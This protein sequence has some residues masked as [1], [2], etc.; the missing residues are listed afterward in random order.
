MEKILFYLKEMLEDT[1]LKIIFSNGSSEALYRK[2]VII[3]KNGYY[4]A[5][6]FT[7][8]QV[9]HEKILENELYGY[10]CKLAAEGYRQINAWGEL[11]EHSL[12][13]SK[14]G[15][16]LY[17]NK[18]LRQRPDIDTSHNRK[19][20]YFLEEGTIIEPLTDMG[21]FTKEGCIVHSMYDKYKQINKFIQIID[22][23]VSKY[24][25]NHLS[26]IDFGCGKSYLTFVVYYY[27]HFVK[28]MNIDIVGLDLKKEVIEKCNT[29]ARKYGYDHL[30]FEVGDINGYR[31]ASHVN[32]VISLHACDTAT[33]F[34]LYNAVSWDAEMI[35]AVPCCQHELCGQLDSPQLSIMQRYGIIKE[36]SSALMTDAIRANLLESR[37]YKSQLLEF[38]DLE[39]TPKNILIRAVKSNISQ[40]H[41]AKM[42]EEVHALCDCFHLNPI[43]L[44]LLAD[45]KG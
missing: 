14:K 27:L 12:R 8:K 28:K 26:I 30:R 44:K 17:Q 24:E 19:K 23:A 22:E 34:V 36:R 21:I 2:T 6:R 29:A 41:R 18:A 33:D 20:N 45:I 42:L 4:Q 3:R 31:P 10:C 5:E 15:N 43:L 7:D 35:I 37:G 9:F 32:L 40:A 16:P 13:I 25:F 11:K 39:H 1:I 38:I